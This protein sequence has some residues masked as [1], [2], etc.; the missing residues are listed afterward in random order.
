MIIHPSIS[1]L[2]ST[3]FF[4]VFQLHNNQLYPA[5]WPRFNSNIFDINY[6]CQRDCASSARGIVISAVH[7]DVFV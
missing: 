5:D 4:V 2:K 6:V 7:V 1:N 3:S